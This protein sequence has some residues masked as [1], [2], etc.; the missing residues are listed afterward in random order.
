M[1]ITKPPQVENFISSNGNTIP[2]QFKIYTNDGV[3]FQ[4]YSTIIAFKPFGSD[5]VYLDRNKWD[6]SRT[7]GKYRNEFLGLNKRETEKDIEAGNIV[8]TDLN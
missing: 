7:T 8:L 5:K 3:Y 6:Y 4:S 2:N 1:K